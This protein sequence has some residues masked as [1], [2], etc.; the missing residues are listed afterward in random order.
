M[1]IKVIT[2]EKDQT[3]LWL[4][5]ELSVLI[6]DLKNNGITV[7]GIICDNAQVNVCAVKLLNGEHIG[8]S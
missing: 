2:K 4:A 7:K 3:S 8:Y 5:Q 1:F 6:K